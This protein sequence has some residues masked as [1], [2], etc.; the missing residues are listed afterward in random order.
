MSEDQFYSCPALV[1]Q[2][3]TYQNYLNEKGINLLDNILL[4]SIYS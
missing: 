3:L 2:Y 1:A 4:P